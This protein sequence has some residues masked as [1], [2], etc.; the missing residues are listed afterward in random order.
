MQERVGD[1]SAR[2]VV[3]SWYAGFSAGSRWDPGIYPGEVAVVN[4]RSPG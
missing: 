2:V 4:S 1:V 3:F